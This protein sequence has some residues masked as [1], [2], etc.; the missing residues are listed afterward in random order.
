MSLKSIK[1]NGVLTLINIKLGKEGKKKTVK[2]SF[3][4]ETYFSSNV[5]SNMI[6]QESTSPNSENSDPLKKLSRR[7]PPPPVRMVTR[8]VSG[9][10]RPKSVDEIL[11]S[12]DVS[13]FLS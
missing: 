8:G 6:K 12:L 3:F 11:S 1:I 13:I 7:L 2:C 4:I 10:V 9:A 5:K